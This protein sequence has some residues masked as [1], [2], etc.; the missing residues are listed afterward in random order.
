MCVCVWGGGRIEPSRK[1][2]YSSKVT[3]MEKQME[4]IGN[5]IEG[6][7]GK[8]ISSV[9]QISES[10]MHGGTKVDATLSKEPSKG[11]SS[12]SLP[13]GLTFGKDNRGFGVWAI[14][15]QP[16]GPKMNKRWNLTLTR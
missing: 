9:A 1:H 11:V 6:E 10:E 8:G 4:C 13:P 5:A 15:E 12:A 16:P 3:T 14:I 2:D 7:V